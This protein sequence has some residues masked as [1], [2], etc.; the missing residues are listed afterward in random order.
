MKRLPLIK[1]L[2]FALIL[3]VGMN[4]YS[5]CDSCSHKTDGSSEGTRDGIDANGD[6]RGSE[7]PADNEN[8]GSTEGTGSSTV[9]D[10]KTTSTTVKATTTRRTSST[11]SANNKDTGLSE[12][13]ITNQIENSDAKSGTVNKKG[14]PVVSS[15]ASGSGTGTG[16]GSTGNNS[17][18]T[19][20]EAQKS[21]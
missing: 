20:R 11:S 7:E 13:E 19:T 5:S 4:I 9:N 6:T 10:G 15:G 21:N 3:I 2:L 18:V 16:T 17:R 14:N 12:A 8:S 1:Q